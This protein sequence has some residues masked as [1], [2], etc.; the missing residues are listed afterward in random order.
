M[1]EATS[2]KVFQNVMN[3]FIIPEIE[4]RKKEGKI[5]ESF[6][7]RS[8]QI[9]L[10]RDNGNSVRLNEE[11][12]AIAK[13]IAAKPIKKNDLVFEEDIKNIEEVKLTEEDKNCAHITLLRFRDKWLIFTDFRYDKED[14][15]E[16]ISASK[17]F[18]ESALENLKNKRLRPFYENA[19][20]S[21]E[22]STKASLML[23]IDKKNL[24]NHSN[25]TK[26]LE[27]WADLGNIPKSFSDILKKLATNLRYSA[28]YL[29]GDDYK[30]ENPEEIATT[31]KE[32]IEFAERNNE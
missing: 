11:V 15:N 18:Y 22:L 8:G 24:N 21:A 19:F 14:S 23:F 26:H 2:Q 25:R 10:S 17:E 5:N 32:M 30:R 1:D 29:E 12:K 20:A 3:L 13:S 27:K 16:H 4:K 28:R 9:V 31:I 6:I 7:L